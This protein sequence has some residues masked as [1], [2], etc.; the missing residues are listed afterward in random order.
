MR[1]LF[2]GGLYSKWDTKEFHAEEVGKR[3]GYYSRA[4]FIRGRLLFATLRYVRRRFRVLT[5]RLRSQDV[6]I[7]SV[8]AVCTRTRWLGNV[9]VAESHFLIAA[10]GVFGLHSLPFSQ[11]AP[12]KDFSVD[13]LM[14]WQVLVVHLQSA[15]LIPT[16]LEQITEGTSSR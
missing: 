11:T 8:Y 6:V 3:C 12:A 15:I 9:A 1:L 5:L 7:V 16:F 2:E 13:Q 10:N 14:R 4:A